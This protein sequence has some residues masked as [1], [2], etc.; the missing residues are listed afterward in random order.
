MRAHKKGARFEES[1]ARTA[2]E[3]QRMRHAMSADAYRRDLPRSGVACKEAFCESS[4]AVS[5]QRL[6]LEFAHA[7]VSSRCQKK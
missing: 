5:E 2:F 3:A 6:R 4:A 7:P 1:G